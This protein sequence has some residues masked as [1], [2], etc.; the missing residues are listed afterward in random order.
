[1]LTCA[2][3]CRK[4]VISEETSEELDVVPMQIRVIKHIAKS[5]VAAVVKRLRLP[6]TSP[7]N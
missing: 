3:G 7:R 4:Y 2:C 5:M 1:M 6:R